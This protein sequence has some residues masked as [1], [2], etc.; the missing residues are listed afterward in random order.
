MGF[1]DALASL[2]PGIT[3]ASQG[4]TGALQ[5][6]QDRRKRERDDAM[7]MI[8]QMRQARL[9]QQQQLLNESLIQERKSQA[10]LRQSQLNS[11]RRAYEYL[12]S[13][14]PEIA[15]AGWDENRPWDV[16]LKDYFD[17]ARTK[18]K[19]IEDQT[20]NFRAGQKL[21]G[22]EPEYQGV[23]EPQPGVDY[24][25]VN[26]GIRDRRQQTFVSE[27]QDKRA[28]ATARNLA[29]SIAA[30]ATR[31]ADARNAP[32]K[33][34]VDA[35]KAVTSVKPTMDAIDQLE[36]T[37]KEF[38]RLSRLDKGRAATG[39]GSKEHDA[40]VGRL[41]TLRGLVKAGM[42]TMEQLGVLQPGDQAFLD[43]QIANPTSPEAILRDPSFSTAGFQTIRD[44][45][46]TR[47]NEFLLRYP[48][49]RLPTDVVTPHEPP[50]TVHHLTSVERQRLKN[51]GYPQDEIDR[52]D[53][54]T[55]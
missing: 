14:D 24:G 9:D 3:A 54:G 36:A 52:L 46:K 45:I 38:A 23:T 13:K 51:A 34:P 40:L 6:M 55:P 50:G 33:P 26:K 39:T 27:Q 30:A 16:M 53:R 15:A 32:P 8:Q 5:G 43:S 29:T 47:E 22:T 48:Q 12:A 44:H 25:D 37:T 2:S 11:R 10:D 21:Y 17:A 35:Q 41:R 7:A 49:L 19:F 31:A 28:A 18:R 4:L 42:G 1:L 20:G